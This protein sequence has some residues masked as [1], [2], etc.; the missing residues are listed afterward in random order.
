MKFGI[1]NAFEMLYNI[2]TSTKG[3]NSIWLGERFEVKQT[4]AWFIRRKVRTAMVSSG[5]N[6][7]DGDVHVD[8]FEIDTPKKGEQGRSK[9]EPKN[10]YCD[11]FREQR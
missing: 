3:A 6:P 8:E 10:S 2:A 5:Q 7:L 9:S 1:E 11:L 4:T